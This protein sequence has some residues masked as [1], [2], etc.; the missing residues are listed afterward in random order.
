MSILYLFISP[1]CCSIVEHC[2]SECAKRK[3]VFCVWL[4][5]NIFTG[6]SDALVGGG[7]AKS[8][9]PTTAQRSIRV[10]PK[11][12]TSQ[13]A[14]MSTESGAAAN[15]AKGIFLDIFFTNIL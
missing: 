8:V 15:S 2:C 13:P 3:L 12:P 10:V 6:A 5:P 9:E 4:Y 7:G 14:A 11:A 1:N